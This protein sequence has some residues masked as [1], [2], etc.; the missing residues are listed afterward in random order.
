MHPQHRN[1][2][3]NTMQPRHTAT[4][5]PRG[6]DIQNNSRLR[7]PHLPKTRQTNIRSRDNLSEPKNT[8][9]R[10]E[11]KRQRPRYKANRTTLIRRQ[12]PKKALQ[13]KL[14]DSTGLCKRNRNRLGTQRKGG[15]TTN[16]TSIPTKTCVGGGNNPMCNGKWS[17]TKD[18]RRARSKTNTHL[19]KRVP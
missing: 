7:H 16:R 3:S 9:R 2:L 15:N 5:Q 8:R 18:V 14:Y 10:C 4:Y 12:R 13:S 19:Y 6:N 11:W 1:N 17:P